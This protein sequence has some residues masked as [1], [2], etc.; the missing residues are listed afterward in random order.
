MPTSSTNL[1]ASR[2]RKIQC[3][4]II[5][6][7]GWYFIGSIL[8]IT[9]SS[10]SIWITIIKVH[11]QEKIWL[12]IT[13][14]TQEKKENLT[15]HIYSYSTIVCITFD[16]PLPQHR[17]NYY[18]HEMTTDP[19]RNLCI[20]DNFGY[21]SKV[22][23]MTCLDVTKCHFLEPPITMKAPNCAFHK[24]LDIDTKNQVRYCVICIIN[25]W[26]QCNKKLFTIPHMVEI[27]EYLQ[28]YYKNTNKKGNLYQSM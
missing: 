10:S 8:T 19:K 5:S 12:I 16:I 22:P 27:K 1:S 26:M 23:L 17:R 3:H 7:I 24:W 18:V 28:N 15:K 6:T 20:I 21:P 13:T 14:T 25:I 9:V 2:I 11:R 4:I